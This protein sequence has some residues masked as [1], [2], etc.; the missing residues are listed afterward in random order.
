MTRVGIA[1]A[2]TSA[3]L[4]WAASPA[5]GVEWLAWVALVPAASLALWPGG[6]RGARLAVPLAYGIYLELLLVPALPFGLDDGQWGDPALP[7]VIGG[8]PGPLVG[9]VA[10]PLVGFLL[11]L[12]RFGQPWGA[13][14]APARVAG[15]LSVLVPAAAWTALELA[16]IKLDPGGVWGP[17]FLSQ[18]G[19]DAAGLAS[20]G[21]PLLVTFAIVACNYALALALVRRRIGLVLAPA[22]T[23]LAALAAGSLALPGPDRSAPITVA[24]VQ[25][26][27]DTAEEDR[28]ET[29]YFEPGTHDLAA[30]DTI[31]DLGE[32]TRAA[33]GQGA[34]IVVW[35]EASMF[36]DPRDETRVRRD[37][38]RLGARVGVP[39]VAPY[40]DWG[41]QRSA[42][43]AVLPDAGITE[44]LP[45]QRPMWFIGEGASDGSPQPLSV[46]GL[47]LGTLLGVDA[48]DPGIAA[49]LASQDADLITSS[50]HDW[51]QLA[52]QQRAMAA[53]TAQA[54]GLPLVRADWRYGSAIYDRDGAVVAD[55]GEAKRRTTVTGTFEVGA[56]T[57]YASLGDAA[58]WTAAAIALIALVSGSAARIGARRGAQVPDEAPETA[59]AA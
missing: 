6:G 22:M 16:R 44:P 58:G 28:P 17:L 15:P 18:S 57:L 1:A 54:T 13:E 19:S 55:A 59:P 48:Q 21:G 11:Y 36:V 42:V 24:A 56:P 38:T 45:K 40:F 27:Y 25:P 50:T 8:T 52:T 3:L 34:E 32:L 31:R 20:L 29:R 12:I 33:A 43:L 37:L 4:L 53:L 10:I 47:A 39:I 2:A 46:N 41:E 26:G 5:V 7:V 35:P 14:H 49:E 9:L 30:R 51:A 23:A